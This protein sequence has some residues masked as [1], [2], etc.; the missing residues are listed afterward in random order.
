METN[1]NTDEAR[2]QLPKGQSNRA[3]S[4]PDTGAGATAEVPKGHYAFAPAAGSASAGEANLSVPEGQWGGASLADTIEAIT[5]QH[6]KRCY[7]MEM[8]KRHDNSLGAELRTGL[9]WSLRLPKAEREAIRVEAAN[10]VELG[11]TY[12]KARRLAGIKNLIEPPLP[13]ALA[14]HDIVVP[15]INMRERIDD[16]EADAT[17]QMERLAMTLPVSGFVEQTRGFGALGLAIIVAEAGDLSRYPKKGHLWKRL[18]IGGNPD[19]T[20]QG[21]VPKGLTREARNAAWVEQKYSP[22]R[23]SRM[24]TIGEALTKNGHSGYVAIYAYRQ[25][26]LDRKAYEKARAEALGL[27]VAPAAKIPKGREA[28]FTSLGHIDNRARRYMEKRLVRDLWNAWRAA[29]LQMPEGQ[30]RGAVRRAA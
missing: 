9:G 6:R 3:E 10:L 5:A 17:R 29:G 8:R 4:V 22:R 1:M 16:L 12:V 25:V 11:E 13:P 24:Y 30:A 27:T 26:Y 7:W 18:G 23:R 19:G 14:Q 15:T 2:L 21:V 28:E 20:R